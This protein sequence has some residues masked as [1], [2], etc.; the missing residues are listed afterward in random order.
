MK[1]PRILTLSMMLKSKQG[2][3]SAEAKS[4]FLLER[5][6]AQNFVP[7]RST[8]CLKS[9]TQSVVSRYSDTA[10]IVAAMCVVLYTSVLF[11]AH[12][13]AEF[14]EKIRRKLTS[15]RGTLIRTRIH[16]RSSMGTDKIQWNFKEFSVRT[17]RKWH[18]LAAYVQVE[19][20]LINID[21]CKKTR[22][23][24][25]FQNDVQIR[26]NSSPPS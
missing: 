2:A 7:K 22:D 6:G 24:R 13:T 12:I 15:E 3:R 10:S 26:A 1:F 5:T 19:I 18:G 9:A 25:V 14:Y 4:G 16:P 23:L 11:L 8:A 17:H 21:W 20:R